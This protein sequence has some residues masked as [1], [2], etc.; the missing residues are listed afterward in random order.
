MKRKN[1][2]LGFLALGILC[3]NV[4][5]VSALQDNKVYKNLN[6]EVTGK[7]IRQTFCKSDEGTVVFPSSAKAG[8]IEIEYYCV[9]QDK[10]KVLDE[11]NTKFYKDIQYVKEKYNIKEDLNNDNWKDYRNAIIN[12][13]VDYPETSQSILYNLAE[14]DGDFDIYEND[15]I[16]NQIEILVK[17]YNTSSLSK[18][19]NKNE[20]A[21]ELDLL[22]PNYS[23]N[24][25]TIKNNSIARVGSSLNVRKAS[26]YANRYAT[27]PNKIDYYFFS[28]GDCT[29]FTSQILEYSGVQQAVYDSEYSGW[30][31]KKIENLGIISEHK[32]SRSW[33]VADTF[34]R[35]MGV[36]VKTTNIKQ[37]VDNLNEGDF[38]AL[39]KKNDGSW[40]HMGYVTSTRN[41]EVMINDP[42]NM[43][44]IYTK[45]D[46]KV[47]QHTSNYNDWLSGTTNGWET[48]YRKAAY[49]RIRG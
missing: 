32:H 36:T 45:K 7:E 49:G 15:E 28:H 3:V 6:K 46:I 33:T 12:V 13:S 22:I 48:Y 37:W 20:I 21:K 25:G 34:A 1:L 19:N 11:I 26:E 40:E 31:H 9:Y 42:V 43:V 8:N 14:I 44:C 18:A 47:A 35:Y 5:N 4:T 39:D 30:W 23:D 10:D 38:I 41:Y 27:N 24:F 17:N 16:N 2:I 29:N